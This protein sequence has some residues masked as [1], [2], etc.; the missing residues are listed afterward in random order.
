MWQKLS[1]SQQ[2]KNP[3]PPVKD[4]LAARFLPRERCAAESY[5]SRLRE[6]CVRCSS[7]LP[8]RTMK[9][10]EN[11]PAAGWRPPRN[12][13]LASV[14]RTWGVP[15]V[16]PCAETAGNFACFSQAARL[17]SARVDWTALLRLLCFSHEVEHRWRQSWIYAHPKHIVHY[18][19]AVAE[20]RQ[21]RDIDNP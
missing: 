8:E 20:D 18:E 2:P 4:S 9:F 16:T 19:V 7:V 10:F 13:Q 11:N 17:P 14:F 5:P 12:S 1:T 6:A 15:P 21:L 3:V